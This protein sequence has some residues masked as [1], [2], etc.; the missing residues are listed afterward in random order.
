MVRPGTGAILTRVTCHAKVGRVV[1]S[2]SIQAE[3]RKEV[4]VHYTC[5]NEIERLGSY[6]A[7]NL[8]EKMPAISRKPNREM[9]R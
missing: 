9:L 2:A 1:L 8:Q 7:C 5:A 4:N 6:K 3:R